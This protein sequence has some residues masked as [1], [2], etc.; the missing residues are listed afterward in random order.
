MIEAI[1][2]N[3]PGEPS[4]ILGPGPLSAPARRKLEERLAAEAH[5]WVAVEPVTLATTPSFDGER[6]VPTPF[7]LRAYVVANETGYHHAGRHGPAR[8]QPHAATLPNGFGS[9]DLWIGATE[10]ERDAPSILRTSMREVHLR[11]TGR[12]LLSRTADNLFWLGRYGERAEGTMRLL[13]SVLSR[14]LED[15][16]PDSNPEVLQRL[17]RLQLQTAAEDE[18][19]PP[20]TGWDGVESWSAS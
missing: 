20:T 4:P 17:L 6:F 16:R 11:R 2:R 18:A 7:A 10:A 9:K 12:D 15:G 1:A 13:R 8:R 3:D 5:R 19:E 14:F